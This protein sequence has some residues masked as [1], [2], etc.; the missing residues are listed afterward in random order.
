MKEAVGMG[1]LSPRKLHRGTW[2]E[3]T[4]TGDPERN[5]HV[6]LSKWAYVS[7]GNPVLENTE[8]RSFLRAFERREEFLI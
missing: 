4:C 6:R 2:R 8:G 1:H 5:C 3:G 7:I